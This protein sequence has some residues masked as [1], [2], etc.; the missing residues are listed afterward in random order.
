MAAKTHAMESSPH[1]PKIIPL[2]SFVHSSVD[3]IVFRLRRT[4][5]W[6][7]LGRSC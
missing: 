7:I 1:L 5:F 3:S 4:R 2:K 6:T